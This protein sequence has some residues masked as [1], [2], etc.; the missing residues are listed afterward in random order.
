MKAMS[1]FHLDLLDQGLNP[2]ISSAILKYNHTE[3]LRTNINR[4]MDI[5]GGKTVML[6]EGNYLANIYQTIP[7]AITVEGANIL[8]RSMI[9]FGQGLM[10]C[11]PFLKDELT[12]IE[13]QSYT[14]FNKYLG[15]HLAHIASVKAKS[16]VFALSGG[17]LSNAPKKHKKALLKCITNN[18]VAS[19]PVLLFLVEM[20]LIKFGTKIKFQESMNGL[21]SDLLIK[22]YGISTLLK[23]VEKLDNNFDDLLK[24][25]MQRHVF[26][27]QMLLKEICDQ[28]KILGFLDG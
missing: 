5:H 13:T 7:I 21:F 18:S 28:F 24:W 10:R 26:E 3:L 23:Y 22:M 4:A 1:N 6:G 8:T 16:L 17:R 15:E 14:S 19:V 9:I 11:H 25:T 2:S 20:V 12:A 27:S